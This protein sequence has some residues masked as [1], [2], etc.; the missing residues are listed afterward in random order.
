MSSLERLIFLRTVGIAS[1]YVTP[2]VSPTVSDSAAFRG[3]RGRPGLALL[4]AFTPVRVSCS[5]APSILPLAVRCSGSRCRN[6]SARYWSDSLSL[7][8]PSSPVPSFSLADDMDVDRKV[9]LLVLVYASER[10]HV[11]RELCL[12]SISI[13]SRRSSYILKRNRNLRISFF[14]YPPRRN[15]EDGSTLSAS[16][17]TVEVEDS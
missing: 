7:S 2:G 1:V 12:D 11:A 17:G 10:A 3:G 4:D 15:S 8:S 9:S 5:T 6:I 13:N 14:H 16:A